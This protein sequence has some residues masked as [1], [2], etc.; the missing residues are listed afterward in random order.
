MAEAVVSVGGERVVGGARPVVEP[1]PRGPL[2]DEEEDEEEGDAAASTAATA[3]STKPT[4]GEIRRAAGVAER[5]K[6]ALGDD[7]SSSSADDLLRAAADAI[8]G[9]EGKG[10]TAA[11]AAAEGGDDEPGVDAPSVPVPGVA[12]PGEGEDGGVGTKE[13]VVYVTDSATGELRR[14]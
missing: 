7:R 8:V 2:G 1:A 14:L 12:S 5:L 3:A 13:A 11:E 6:R 10:A 9:E 4:E